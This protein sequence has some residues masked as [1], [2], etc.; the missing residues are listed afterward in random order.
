MGPARGRRLLPLRC[1]VLR[2]TC[3]P[4]PCIWITWARR[5]WMPL[6][7]IFWCSASVIP[8]LRTSLQNIP[9]VSHQEQALTA[10]SCAD[11]SPGQSSV[12][13][14]PLGSYGHAG[15]RNPQA[16]VP[17]EQHRPWQGAWGDRSLQHK[18]APTPAA[19]AGGPMLLAEPPVGKSLLDLTLLSIWDR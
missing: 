13:F 14:R 3:T 9:I 5:V 19:G 18:T 16:V 2:H 8:R 12:D 1:S 11:C 15:V 7:M 10:A 17:A 4:R 6:R